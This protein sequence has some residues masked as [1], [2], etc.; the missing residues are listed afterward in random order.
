ME[1]KQPGLEWNSVGRFSKGSWSLGKIRFR[2][3]TLLGRKTR[4]CSEDEENARLVQSVPAGDCPRRRKAAEAKTRVA[5]AL[6][7]ETGAL[8]VGTTPEMRIGSERFERFCQTILR[9]LGTF[10]MLSTYMAAP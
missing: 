1:M 6:V 9:N 3:L 10:P 4:G 7:V 2:E 5:S 8:K